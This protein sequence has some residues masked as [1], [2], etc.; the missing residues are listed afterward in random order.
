MVWDGGRH[1]GAMDEIFNQLPHGSLGC[2]CRVVPIP[3]FFVVDNEYHIN[4]A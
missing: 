1:C 4:I 2:L 3:L